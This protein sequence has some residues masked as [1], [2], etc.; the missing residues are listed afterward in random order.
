MKV[1]PMMIKKKMQDA[2]VEQINK[3]L[4]S[5]YLYLSMSAWF[6]GRGLKG[7]ANWMHKQAQEEYEH[8]M[9]FF[10]YV[11]ERGGSVVMKAIDKPKSTWKSPLDAFS[12]ALAH[13]RKVTAMIEN[14]VDIARKEKDKAS[15]SFLQWYVDEQVEEEAN[16]SEIID[17]LT[18]SKNAPGAMVFIDRDLGARK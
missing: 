10:N 5:G 15:E 7:M 11:Y 12:D 4:Y 16:A 2:I 18:L 14:L 13:E 6:E 17:K 3:E 9:K 8:A 1:K